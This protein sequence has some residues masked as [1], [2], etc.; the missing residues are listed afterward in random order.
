M[1]IAMNRFKVTEGS[2]SDF[3][4]V[5]QSRESHLLGMDG[6]VEFKLLRGPHDAEGGYTLFASH[7]T[8]RS[9]DDFEAWTRSEQFRKAHANAG[10]GKVSYLGHP[11]LE[12]FD[13][14]DGTFVSA[15]A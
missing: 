9:R 15:A 3:E 10:S 2:E 1:F 4:T 5:W 6:F 13:T 11:Q 14:V 8:W 7:T 12:T